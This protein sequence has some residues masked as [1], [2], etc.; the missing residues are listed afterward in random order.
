[1]RR[2]ARATKKAPRFG[3]ATLRCAALSV[4]LIMSSACSKPAKDE[5]GKGASGAAEASKSAAEGG[6]KLDR[7]F[8]PSKILAELESLE[9]QGSPHCSA[10][11]EGLR[12]TLKDL[13]STRQALDV[14]A[15]KGSAVTLL[16]DAATTLSKN[17]SKIAGLK[18]SDE[19]QR[20]SAE[21]TATLG[22]LAES[23]DEASKALAGDDRPGSDANHLRTANA[24]HNTLA[25]IDALLQQCSTL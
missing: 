5:P 13:A 12:G 23:L 11:I 10:T 6:G 24:V 21:L 14:A 16:R 17:T 4:T 3:L 9:L 7:S 19:E 25:A 15:N 20:I 18:G 8:L 22:D 1:M 2:L